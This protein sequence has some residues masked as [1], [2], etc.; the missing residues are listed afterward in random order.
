VLRAGG[1]SEHAPASTCDQGVTAWGLGP[2]PG[3]H[4]NATLTIVVSSA[5]LAAASTRTQIKRRSAGSMPSAGGAVALQVASTT[6]QA[7]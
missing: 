2:G 5:G 1:C 3:V 4:G 7:C 6:N